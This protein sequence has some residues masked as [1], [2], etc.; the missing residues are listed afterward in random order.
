MNKVRVLSLL[1]LI[2]CVSVLSLGLSNFNPNL[3]LDALVNWLWILLLL[4]GIY[5]TIASVSIV[6]LSFIGLKTDAD[7]SYIV[8]KKN[9]YGRLFISFVAFNN[10]DDFSICNAFWK[11]NLILFLGSILV[12]L[13]ITFGIF[14]YG[15]GI[16]DTAILVTAI[17]ITLFAFYIF[18]VLCELGE[19]AYDRLSVSKPKV[20]NA[21]EFVKYSFYNVIAI[22]CIICIVGLIGV[23]G[24]ILYSIGM[25]TIWSLLVTWGPYLAMWTIMICANVAGIYGMLKLTKKI[26]GEEFSSFY[27]K[28]LCP[29]IKIRY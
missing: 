7:N 19:S 24:F 21:I 17:A 13:V 15:K 23:L 18:A 14:I 3:P 1:A 9:L 11:T 2:T 29:K 8:D 16:K 4:F 5:G 25:T 27:H 20:I 10:R 28:N 6:I 22:G 26:F 12:G